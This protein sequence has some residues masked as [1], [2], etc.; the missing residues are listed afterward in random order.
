MY[1]LTPVYITK[2]KQKKIESIDNIKYNYECIPKNKKICNKR[3]NEE[4]MTN[5]SYAKKIKI[6]NELKKDTQLTRKLGYTFKEV[7]VFTKDIM[8][9]KYK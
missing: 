7:R 8:Q 4:Q 2:L 5:E 6:S 9:K 3:K 1:E